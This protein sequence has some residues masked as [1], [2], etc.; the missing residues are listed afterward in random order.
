MMSLAS[1]PAPARARSAGWRWLGAAGLLQLLL[2]VRTFARLLLH[3]SQYLLVDYYDGIR[4][5][6]SLATFLRQPLSQGLLDHGTNYPFGEYIFYTD[7]APGFSIPLHW[8]VRAVPALAPYGLY[9]FDVF[10]LL[11]IVLSTLLLLSILRRLGL[12]G[13]VALLLSLALPWLGPQASRLGVGHLALSYT[14]AVLGPLWLLQGLY[15]AWRA[16]RP[17]GRWWVALAGGLIAASWVHF[18]YLGIMG[19]WTGC[20][21]LLWLGREARAGRPWRRLAGWG[22]AALAT[23]LVG[24]FGLLQVLD[25]RRL[26]RPAGSD[27]YDWIE[28]KFQFTTLFK[29]Y[30]YNKIKFLLERTAAVPYE[31]NSYLG[32]FVLYGLV[33]V[34]VLAAVR[35]WQQ[36]PAAPGVAASPGPALLPVLPALGEVRRDW[37]GLVLLSSLP[38]LLVALGEEIHFDNDSYILQNYLNPFVWLHKF[39]VRVTQ[40]RAL[41]RF[42]WPFWWALVLGFA[43]YA[44]LAW[45]QATAGRRRG[46]QVLWA[47]LVG[48]AVV[49]MV[50]ATKFYRTELT[51][52]NL[53]REP[54]TDKVRALVGWPEPGRYQALLPLPYWH[55][56]TKVD[57]LP[58]L[59]VDPDD[60]HSNTGYQLGV[61]TGLP[62]MSNK[63]GRTPGYQAA[64]LQSMFRPGGPDPALLARL[65]QRPILVFLDTAYYDGRNNFYREE[66]KNWPE[67]L[68]LFERAPSF[69]REQHMR[70]L[71]HEGSWSLYEWQPKQ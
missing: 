46:L 32:A 28:W 7:I 10:I 64:E 53:L 71:R 48:L 52:V 35:W 5:Y 17:L 41:G 23:T 1:E 15:G 3:P 47:V 37:L 13:W 31:S 11:G 67:V 4:S 39:T 45:Q 33:A 14:P 24:T 6:Y 49:D 26:E 62:L 18:Y 43:R 61:V 69:I 63:A 51:R 68:A 25:S 30:A 57:D 66:L 50:H 65:D 60:P 34:A 27:G 56:G 59:G 70:R 44:G 54:A 12:P 20:F 55:Q 9:V 36:R 2:V 21:L 8:L 40:F 42:V 16:G 22:G 38:L 58:Y 29:S 19:M